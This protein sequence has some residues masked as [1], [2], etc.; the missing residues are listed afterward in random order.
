MKRC[1]LSILLTAT[2][3]LM[4]FHPSHGAASSSSTTNMAP[5][6]LPPEVTQFYKIINNTK[7]SSDSNILT[8]ALPDGRKYLGWDDK[9]PTC[10]AISKK[11]NILRLYSQE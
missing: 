1:H 3:S 4:Q 5:D 10:I 6:C 8:V 9:I 2:T 7:V 11:E